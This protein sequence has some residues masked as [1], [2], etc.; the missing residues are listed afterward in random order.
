MYPF[1]LNY[2]AI[3]VSGNNPQSS[4]KVVE[5]G[6]ENAINI[7]ILFQFRASDKLGLVGG[8]RTNETL[9]NIKYTKKI[10]IDLY[11]YKDVP[12]SFDLQVSCRYKKVTSLDAPIIPTGNLT[13]ATF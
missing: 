13:S 11:P 7:P 4:S 12:F 1:P 3:S 8:F 10:G 5:Y 9:T 6:S 2:D